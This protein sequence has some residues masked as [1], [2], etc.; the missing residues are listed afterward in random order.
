VDL[1]LCLTLFRKIRLIH[2]KNPGM[3]LFTRF[4]HLHNG[5]IGILRLV[6]VSKSLERCGSVRN[7]AEGWES[8]SEGQER[9]LGV[10]TFAGDS[11]TVLQRLERLTESLRRDFSLIT[12]L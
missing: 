5:N 4:G 10:W 11:G 7:G 9:W 1:R 2:S 12:P 6:T 3:P 8:V